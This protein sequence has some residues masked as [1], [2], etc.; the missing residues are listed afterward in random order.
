MPALDL[1]A[2]YGRMV[3][4]GDLA[5]LFHASQRAIRVA[6]QSRAVPIYEFGNSIVVPLRAV[7]QAFGLAVLVADADD[8][9]VRHQAAQFRSRFHDNGE[10]KSLDEYLAEVDARAGGWLADIDRARVRSATQ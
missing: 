6:L 3:P 2:R 5:R 4:I 7:E 9:Q 10:R 8:D 1:E